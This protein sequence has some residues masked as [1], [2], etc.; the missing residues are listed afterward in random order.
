MR[1]ARSYAGSGP[2]LFLEVVAIAD[3]QEVIAW[4]RRLANLDTRVFDEVR[5]NPTATIPGFIV[6]AVSIFIAGLGGWLW[7]IVEDF[8]QS[9]DILVNSA[10]IGSLLAIVLW[11]LWLLI[12]Y[13]TLTTVFRERAYVEQLL[14]VMGLA[15][16]PLALM[17]FMFIPYISLAI[18][19]ASLALTFGLTN[20][21]IRSVTTAD[22][23]RVL[24]ANLLGFTLWSAA[25]TLLAASSANSYEPHAP[26]VF[27]F[28]TITSIASDVFSPPV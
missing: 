18:G 2:G 11:V 16:C 24:V 7:W 5:T 20:I 15:A 22:P 27:L 13:V 9:G 1:L 21:A 28:N 25:L 14:R 8:G 10:F 6:A 19:L 4:L 23:A 12:V 3:M 17:G 26:G